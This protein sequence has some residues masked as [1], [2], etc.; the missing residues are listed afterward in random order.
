MR[1]TELALAVTLL[2]P[3]AGQAVEL[4]DLV[5][6]AVADGNRASGTL[7][8]KSMER[9]VQLTKTTGEASATVEVLGPLPTEAEVC[10]QLRIVF[11]VRDV[12]TKEGK[13]VPFTQTLDMP[14]CPSQAGYTALKGTPGLFRIGR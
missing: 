5:R 10:R 14:W 2:L 6:Q 8:G 3:V 7:T 13:R 4:G 12:A 11:Y 1:R 9:I